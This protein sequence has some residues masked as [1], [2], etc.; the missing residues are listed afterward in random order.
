MTETIIKQLDTL[1]PG[2]KH[3]GYYEVIEDLSVIEGQ[4]FVSQL[5]YTPVFAEKFKKRFGHSYRI[6]A[7]HAYELIRLIA[8]AFEG[9]S[10]E[11]KPTTAEAR[12]HLSTLKDF[13]S[14][15]GKLSVNGTRNIEHPNVFKVA[16]G[17]VL[18]KF[19]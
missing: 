8:Y 10:K 14:V 16:K 6:R 18:E 9:V 19:E 1:R 4:P 2:T 7:P 12:D 13:D 3:S 5:G 11:K 17:G 15:L